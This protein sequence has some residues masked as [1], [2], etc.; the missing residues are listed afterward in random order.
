MDAVKPAEKSANIS[1][2]L[3]RSL[4]APQGDIED[5]VKRIDFLRKA[6]VEAIIEHSIEVADE[7]V[8]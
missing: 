6:E 3:A 5:P 2:A 7:E 4:G 1:K 8:R